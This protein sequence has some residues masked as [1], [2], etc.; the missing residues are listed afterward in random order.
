MPYNRSLIPA[1]LLLILPICEALHAQ[2]ETA[3]ET[4]YV[5]DQVTLKMYKDSKLSQALPPLEPGDQV[6][7]L[8]RDDNY[9]EIKLA[10]GTQGWV[11]SNRLMADKPAVVEMAELRQKLDRLQSEY[12][13]LLV[14]IAE[15]ANDPEP[16]RRMEAAEAARDK[17]QKR[18][19]ELETENARQFQ[20]LEGLRHMLDIYKYRDI[21]IWAIAPLLALLVGFFI[22]YRYL[23]R[24]IRARFG[25]H[26]LA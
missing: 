24:R 11:R 7:I 14:Q 22:G 17:L 1:A 20:E 21:L 13:S 4:L 25:G 6:Q 19:A 2:E 5:S 3:L 16:V 23:D 10:D 26:S 12:D 8:R 18:T 15:A 9:A